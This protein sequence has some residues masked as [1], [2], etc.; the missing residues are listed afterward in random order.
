MFFSLSS[1]ISTRLIGFS[2]AP[3]MRG[4]AATT[5]S[6]GAPSLRKR[7]RERERGTPSRLALEPDRAAVQFDELARERE[8]EAR[9]FLLAGVIAS[10]LPELFEHR[11]LIGR[12]NAD[13]GVAHGDLGKR[14]GAPRRHVDAS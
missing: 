11:V 8:A 14:A 4:D 5:A 6:R 3:A 10:D 12:G 2:L 1:T 9:A 13:A 7:N